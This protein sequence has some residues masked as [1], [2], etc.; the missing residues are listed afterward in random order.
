MLGLFAV[1]SLP[2]VVEMLAAG[3]LLQA[4]AQR[5]STST[6]LART[7]DRNADSSE[8]VA[9]KRRVFDTHLAQ[10]VKTDRRAVR[11]PQAFHDSCL[12]LVVRLH[13]AT[14]TRNHISLLPAE[15]SRKAR[16]I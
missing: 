1:L 13:C 8:L 11:G 5:E 4:N 6:R 10:L 2:T 14:W 16:K 3:E 9:E 15:V 12:L 7:F